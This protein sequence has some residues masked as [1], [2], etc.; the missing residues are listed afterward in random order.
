MKCNVFN[1]K[2]KGIV[3]GKINEFELCY[4]QNH[5]DVIITFLSRFKGKIND[6]L[7]SQN[8]LRYFDKEQERIAEQILI[9]VEKMK[10]YDY[11]LKTCRRCG[12]V[13]KTI[14]NVRKFCDDC[15]E[16]LKNYDE[17]ELI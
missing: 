15:N 17:G 6:K 5:L 16:K 9:E 13:F 4:C 7:S 10:K 2:K 1:C 14:S 3:F 8:E 11:Y 12:T